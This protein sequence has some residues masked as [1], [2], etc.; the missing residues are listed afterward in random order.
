MNERMNERMNEW[1]DGWMDEQMMLPHE[2][3]ECLRFECLCGF[4]LC[5]FAS[6]VWAKFSQVAKAIN[7]SL[8]PPLLLFFFLGSGVHHHHFHAS[9]SKP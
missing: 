7:Q 5:F 4:M 8:I 6:F 1:M 2:S 3:H 9:L